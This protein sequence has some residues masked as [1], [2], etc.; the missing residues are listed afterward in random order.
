MVASDVSDHFLVSK[1]GLIFLQNIE[2]GELT[3]PQG[4]CYLYVSNWVCNSRHKRAD[5]YNGA[6]TYHGAYFDNFN[7]RTALFCKN[8]PK[9]CQLDIPPFQKNIKFSLKLVAFSRNLTNFVL[10]ILILHNRGHAILFC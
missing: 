7:F 3:L 2:L 5:Y 9:L 1:I 8:V 4:M 6:C 10:P